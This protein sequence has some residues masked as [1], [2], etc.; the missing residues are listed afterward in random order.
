MDIGEIGEESQKSVYF[1]TAELHSSDDE[2][3][4]MS[5][6]QR[7]DD[8]MLYSMVRMIGWVFEMIDSKGRWRPEHRKFIRSLNPGFLVGYREYQ[9]SLREPQTRSAKLPA[10][11]RLLRRQSKKCCGGAAMSKFWSLLLNW[12][13]GLGL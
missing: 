8:S 3:G 10:H 2:I 7:K 1:T 11:G 6:L 4:M 9:G 12:I 5:C 13:L